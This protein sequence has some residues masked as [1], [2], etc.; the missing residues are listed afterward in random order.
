MRLS[1]CTQANE[2]F[3]GSL[4]L[5]CPTWMIT[6]A[7]GFVAI[8]SSL[9]RG[10]GS[11]KYLDASL[12]CLSCPVGKW[13]AGATVSTTCLDCPVGKVGT[14]SSLGCINCPGGTFVN[15]TGQTSLGSCSACSPGSFSPAGSS[16][17]GDCPV[18]TYPSNSSCLNC[19]AGFYAE[20]PKSPA[21]SA[22]ASG[23]YSDVSGSSVCTV[24]NAGLFSQDNAS[25]CSACPVG[26]YSFSSNSAFCSPCEPGYA[27]V[28][29]SSSCS[30][31]KIGR[32]GG[33]SH[34]L[35]CSQLATTLQN[36]SISADACV[37]GEGMYGRPSEGESCTF[38][39]ANVGG[40]SCPANGSYPI[41]ENGYFRTVADPS[42]ALICSPQEACSNAQDAKFTQCS[43]GYTWDVCGSCILG[44]SYR[45]GLFC[46]KCPSKLA[47]GILIATIVLIALGGVFRFI[48]TGFR[49]S[50]EVKV[51]VLW[52]Q[53]IATYP[54][55]SSNWPP[56]IQKF[57]D[58]LS[59]SNLDFGKASPGK[60]FNFILDHH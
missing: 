43:D 20:F 58:V 23:R 21:C 53:I 54:S 8:G 59:F 34:C 18:G 13:T 50:T 10:C 40:V 6:N 60:I 22:C 4:C 24:C 14:S 17:C 25:S 47:V 42:V 3:N 2:Y 52:I 38:C 29:G 46:L 44:Y 55:V 16:V 15:S 51:T 5:K 11:G 27:T 48:K 7:T 26:K 30:S 35:Q 39:K 36:A 45:Q 9:C 12:N 32:Y 33:G 19:S 28:V 56:A 31:C 41:V 37:C 1:I 57:F 49:V